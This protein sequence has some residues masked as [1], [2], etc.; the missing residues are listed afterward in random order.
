MIA[1]VPMGSGGLPGWR[2]DNEWNTGTHK[3]VCWAEKHCKVSM[4]AATMCGRDGP[5]VSEQLTL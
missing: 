5:R 3:I 1:A 4:S 2:G